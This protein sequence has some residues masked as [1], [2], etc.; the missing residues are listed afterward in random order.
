MSRATPSI[1]VLALLVFD[2]AAQ[3]GSIDPTFNEFDPGFGYGDGVA[4]ANSAVRVV[5][6]Q[7]D[8]KVLVGGDFT[9]YNSAVAFGLCRT[10]DHGALDPTF[11]TPVAGIVNAVQPLGDGS[12]IV[13]GD[14][15]LG[16]D[17]PYDLVRLQSD[18]TED[19]AFNTVG[20]WGS[21]FGSAGVNAIVEQPD[22]KILLAGL[23]E[24]YDSYTEADNIVRLEA[25]GA[26][27][28]SF[29]NGQG[30]DAAGGNSAIRAMA[31]QPDGKILIAGDFT[32]YD[33]TDRFHI[34][35]LNS[36][37]TLDPTFDPGTG[38][39]ATIHALRV[40]P[41][42]KILIGGE[43]TS[44]NGTSRNHIAR[45]LADGSLDTTFDPGSGAE[46]DALAGTNGTI[47]GI[48]V[49]TDGTVLIG[50]DFDSF[51]GTPIETVARLFPDGALDPT[52]EGGASPGANANAVHTIAIQPD[53]RL[54]AGGSFGAY[55]GSYR[56][57]LMRLQAD[58][59]VDPSYNE[60]TASTGIV[61][62][63]VVQPDGKCIVNARRYFGAD[64]QGLLRIHGD[65]STDTTFHPPV[66]PTSPLY[67]FRDGLVQ[68]DGR[69]VLAVSGFYHDGVLYQGAARFLPNG[70]ID[71]TFHALG[72]DYAFN[73]PVYTISRQTDGKFIIGGDLGYN[74]GGFGGS[75]IP[76]LARV[77]GAGA[78]DTTFIG[79]GTNEGPD[80]AVLRSAIQ[81]DGRI[82]VLGTFTHMAGMARNGI[83]RLNSD[84]SLDTTFDPGSHFTGPALL[85]D[86]LVLP[87]GKIVLV[88]GF[89]VFDGVARNNILRLGSDGSLDL[90]FDPGTGTDLP[91]NFIK[92]DPVGASLICGEFTT[93]NGVARNWLARL[94]E[95][96]GLD[97]A[98]DTGTGPST[99]L[100]IP[101]LPT[102]TGLGMLPDGDMIV[103]GAFWSW[104]GIGRNRIVRLIGGLSTGLGDHD[105]NG[106]GASTTYAPAMFVPPTTEGLRNVRILDAQGRLVRE[107]D[108]LSIPA[109]PT[110]SDL[111]S[112]VYFVW[113]TYG[114][115][116]HTQRIVVP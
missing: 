29:D 86:L 13:G 54:V 18:G 22:G 6:V 80:G 103:T 82:I 63:C 50:G 111:P 116:C 79:F 24:N 15:D 14:F 55:K 92:V 10:L 16:G 11:V 81:P 32:W 114:D 73:G 26:L 34:A 67:D 113:A 19:A 21:A 17:P 57:G 53:G 7:P 93:Y 33:G 56:V 102:I 38:T 48:A 84:G 95:D 108:P 20:A 31:L 91:I 1:L 51:D 64:R 107:V 9:R 112:G 66:L 43:F 70:A 89:S 94:A 5:V 25:N 44:V 52:F 65:G 72:E 23:F 98:F 101:P 71:T 78:L 49:R 58:G 109:H 59:A 3:P 87:D 8:G 77:D 88:G 27:D 90:T 106:G 100:L 85:S 35:R 68:P 105:Q 83:A 110:F 39:D 4:P 115:R 61:G 28:S 42:G 74:S 40:L 47:H 96:G 104:N 41:S 36:D 46:G 62:A 2:S 37:G 97:V 60:P 12:M 75:D 76:W 45:L 30:A 69:I 99:P